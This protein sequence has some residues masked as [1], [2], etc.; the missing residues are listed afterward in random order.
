MEAA[1]VTR[2]AVSLSPVSVSSMI[3]FSFLLDPRIKNLDSL[4]YQI[5][6][7]QLNDEIKYIYE[8]IDILI[9]KNASI[10]IV[11]DSTYK[12]LIRLYC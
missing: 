6:K 5:N 9:G 12:E 1:I 11:I 2:V 7:N 3:S 8:V 4:L 10:S